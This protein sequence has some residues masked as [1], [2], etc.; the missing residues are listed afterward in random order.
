MPIPA[1][2]KDYALSHMVS[3]TTAPPMKM[4]GKK[5]VSKGPRNRKWR[6]NMAGKYQQTGGPGQ[7]KIAPFTRKK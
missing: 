2:K 3:K 6:G 7:R 4:Q 1:A 5:G